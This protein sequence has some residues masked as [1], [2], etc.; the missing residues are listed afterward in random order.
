MTALFPRPAAAVALALAFAGL[1]SLAAAQGASDMIF[2][3]DFEGG[4][5]AAWSAAST[6]GGDLAVAPEAALGS[7]SAGLRALVNDT[8]GLF[9]EDDTPLDENRYRARFLFDPNGFDP[10]EGQGHLRT[11]L[12]IL[13]EENPTRR[14]MAVVL[15]RLAGAYSLE[16]RTRVDSNAQVDTGFFPITDA[17]HSVEIDWRRSSGPDASDGELALWLDGVPTA[18]ET[19][20]DNSVSAVDFVRLGALSVKSGASG[21]LFLDEFISRR[22]YPPDAVVP[23]TG[24]AVITEIMA[25]PSALN[26]SVGEW[27]EISNP[28]AR[29]A[30]LAGCDVSNQSAATYGIT[31]IALRPGA[32]A[33]LARSSSPGFTPDEVWTVPLLNTSGSLT[34]SCGATEIDAVSWT[35]TTAGK[36]RELSRSHLDAVSNDSDAN[37]CLATT[38]YGSGDLGTPGV[39]NACP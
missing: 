39:A 32:F 20:L 37:W 6:D 28:T 29:T 23:G 10:G 3:D 11:R 27:I 18:D 5:L 2:A 1:P 31:S 15:R 17:P 13:F 22:L 19:G 34:L 26:D 9:V 35:S 21:T 25:D 4:T 14:L 7:T 16:V 30:L 24:G 12:F 36:S 8:N 33:T 38:V